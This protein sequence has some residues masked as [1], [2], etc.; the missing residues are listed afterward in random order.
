MNI[1]WTLRLHELF[2]DH[3][4]PEVLEQ[5]QSQEHFTIVYRIRRKKSVQKSVRKIAREQIDKAAGEI[6]DQNL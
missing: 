3:N 5:S 2:A 4:I 6:M 1:D